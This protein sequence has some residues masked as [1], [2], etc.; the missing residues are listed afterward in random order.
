MPILNI[1]ILQGHAAAEKSGLLRA[2]SGAVVQSIAAPLSSVRIVLHEVP[3]GHVIVAGEIGK[4][5]AQVDVALIEGRDEA[6]RRR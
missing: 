4:R 5:M 6:R 1:Q 2:A 3:A